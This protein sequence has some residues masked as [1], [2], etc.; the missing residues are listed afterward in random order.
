MQMHCLIW[1]QTTQEKKEP[2]Q[3]HE[4]EKGN[5]HLQQKN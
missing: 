5:Y 2:K 1:K 3:E 4:I